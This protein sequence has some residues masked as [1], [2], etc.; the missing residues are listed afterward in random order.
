V[1]K[2]GLLRK[3]PLVDWYLEKFKELRKGNQRARA[4]EALQLAH[5]A[6]QPNAIPHLKVHLIMLKFAI[7]MGNVKEI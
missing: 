7:Q 1:Q 5:I 4:W 2:T 3:K 6:P